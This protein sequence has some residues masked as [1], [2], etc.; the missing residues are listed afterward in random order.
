MLRPTAHALPLVCRL[1]VTQNP[2]G[3]LQEMTLGVWWYT[4]SGLLGKSLVRVSS[5]STP[6]STP[7]GVYSMLSSV[8]CNT[9]LTQPS[10][11]T[12][13]RLSL[14]LSLKE[15]Q[16]HLGAELTPKP[17]TNDHVMLVFSS[18]SCDNQ[19]MLQDL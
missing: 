1:A 5:H 3:L 7:S 6:T 8:I 17:L 14:T 9:C 19:A 13:V 18:V 15:Q 16:G 10:H 4:N 2:R 11:E 12:L